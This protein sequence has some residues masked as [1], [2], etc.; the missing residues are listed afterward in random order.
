MDIPVEIVREHVIPY[1]DV[2]V[3][4]NLRS[5]CKLYYG[6]GLWEFLLRRDFKP[7]FDFHHEYLTKRRAKTLY[8]FLTKKVL[9]GKIFVFKKG[10]KIVEIGGERS[11]LID[12]PYKYPFAE[13]LLHICHTQGKIDQKCNSSENCRCFNCSLARLIKF[14]R[15]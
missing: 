2:K 5:T 3:V 7:V 1:C 10:E 12:F 14:T 13:K 11:I 8:M 15:E 6:L 9:P 4:L